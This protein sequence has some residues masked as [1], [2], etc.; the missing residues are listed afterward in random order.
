MP[1]AP[2][3]T[4][5][6][7]KLICLSELVAAVTQY[8]PDPGWKGI[9]PM[10]TEVGEGGREHRP[11]SSAKSPGFLLRGAEGAAMFHF[12]LLAERFQPFLPSLGLGYM[13]QE[14]L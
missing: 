13:L 7:Y 12:A 14:T 1:P 8:P 9:C 11:G 10:G 2:P 4:P 6:V 5:V 3:P